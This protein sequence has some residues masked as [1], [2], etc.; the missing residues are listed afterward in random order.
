MIDLSLNPKIIAGLVA[1][2][3]SWR[4]RNVLYTIIGGMTIFWLSRWLLMVL[5]G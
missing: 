3:I 1:I 2:L 5:V 4:T